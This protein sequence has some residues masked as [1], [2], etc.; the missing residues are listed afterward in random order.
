MARTAREKSST[1]IYAVILRG[2]ENIFSSQDMRDAFTA[3]A[4][5]Y[6]GKGLL[7]IRFYDDKVHMLV[8]ESE[9]GISLDMKPLVTSFARTYNREHE[10]EGKVF[11]DRFKSVPVESGAIQKECIDYLNGG[12]IASP[13]VSGVRS[14]AVVKKPIK[15]K[16]AVK[17]TTGKKPVR[18]VKEEPVQEIKPIKK[19]KTLPSWLL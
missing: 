4:E 8:K 3:A 13:Y 10:I 11:K 17:K 9:S 15:K 2:N 16:P 14:S 1:G 19:K 7:G 6:L 5:K 12:E 18:T